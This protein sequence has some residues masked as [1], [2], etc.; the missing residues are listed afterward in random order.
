MRGLTIRR[1]VV[2]AVAAVAG[3]ALISTA[4]PAAAA[5]ILNVN[6][7]KTTTVSDPALGPAL[8]GAGILPLP[9]QPGTLD[10]LDLNTLQLTTTLP[11]RSGTLDQ[12]A[13]FAGD[14]THAGGLQFINLLKFRQVTVSDFK[15]FIDFADPRL[16]ATVNHDPKQRIKLFTIDI[17]GVQFGGNGT[18]ELQLNNNKLVLT[19]EGAALLN[20]KLRTKAFVAGAVFGTANTTF[21]YTVAP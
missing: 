5:P 8:I 21:N 3:A 11:V 10:K 7:G 17:S 1:R 4:T 13:F 18:S 15:V 9:V 6:G 16:E 2:V 20:D 14:A 12:G 19:P